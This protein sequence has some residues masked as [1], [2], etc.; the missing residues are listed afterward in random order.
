MESSI[1]DTTRQEAP[2]EL[3]EEDGLEPQSRGYRRKR[4]TREGRS[5]PAG[6]GTAVSVFRL[7]TGLLHRS[8]GNDAGGEI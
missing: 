1:D 5:P 3:G 4:D 6:Q 7:D 8:A 2:M